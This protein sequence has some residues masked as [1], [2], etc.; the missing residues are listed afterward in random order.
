[1]PAVGPARRP[2]RRCAAFASVLLVT[3]A[4]LGL[5]ASPAAAHA[6]LVGAD[7][8][9]GGAVEDAPASV[10]LRFNEPVVT[11]EGS[12][13]VFAADGS[14]VDRGS[15]DTGTAAEVEVTLP[16]VLPDGGYVVTYRV[17]SLDSHP[18]AGTTTFTVGTGEAVDPD[19]VAQLGGP[20]EG[21]LGAVGSLL[22]GLG[23]L[24]TLLA[25]GAV[26]FAAGV[27]HGRPDRARSRAVAR[28]AAVAAIAVAIVHVPVQTMAVTGSGVLDAVTSSAL[29]DTVASSFGRSTAVRLLGL[30]VLI[31]AWTRRPRLP[32]VGV[33]A[34]V[35]LGSYLLDG[36]QRTVEPTWLLVGADAVHLAA[37]AVWLGGLV[38]LALTL[39]SRRLDDDPLGAA[40]VVARF[41]SLALWSVLVLAVAGVAMAV[42]LVGTPAALLTTT[43]GALLLG[44]VG[45]VL[46]AVAIAVHNRRRLVPA[47]EAAVRPAGG[48]DTP[49]ATVAAEP[50]RGSGAA[51]WARLRS[52]VR[53]EVGLVAA[54][55]LVTGFLA[56]TQPASEAAAPTGPVV[57]EA[58]L[59]DDLDVQLTI[60]PPRAG[61]VTLHVYVLEPGGI[62]DR[63]EDL[64]LEFTSVPEGVGPFV[65]EPLPAGP[66]HWTASIEDL[67]FPG[68]WEARIVGGIGR[69]DE[70]ETTVGFELAP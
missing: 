14:R 55:V 40:V 46:L 9:D 11:S 22:R 45:L 36:H 56:T 20:G 69:F 61:R 66:G 34:A 49:A 50:D 18:V 1:M 23:Y 44:K 64:R 5:M 33:A 43:Y 12:V 54:A 17:V 15:V 29:V 24:G 32:V 41:S 60:D 68:G 10:T 65:V 51:A 58:P 27:A 62:S 63:V 2:T 28:A 19:V 59:A 16:D 6:V 47:V 57:L 39:R 42:V 8:A 52:T 48:S 3:V 35:A 4:L 21:L 31:L 70:V 37:G 7:P 26:A 53:A 67:R 38:L 13:R 25:A 30:G